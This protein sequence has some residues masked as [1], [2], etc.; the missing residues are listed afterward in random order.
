MLCITFQCS[1]ILTT[2]FLSECRGHSFS[3]CNYSN[4]CL[5]VCKECWCKHQQAVNVQSPNVNCLL[6]ARQN[7]T[8][9]VTNRL[10]SFQVL[11]R[12]GFLHFLLSGLYFKAFARFARFALDHALQLGWAQRPWPVWSGPRT[13]S[14]RH[15]KLVRPKSIQLDQHMRK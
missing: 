5:T 1:A 7:R 10:K 8:R 13:K 4:R 11:A 3:W 9:L 12:F 14:K 15:V 6:C 2:P